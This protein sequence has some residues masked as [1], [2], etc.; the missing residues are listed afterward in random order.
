MGSD[1]PRGRTYDSRR[2][3]VALDDL[4]GDSVSGTTVV[5]LAGSVRVRFG[6]FDVVVGGTGQSNRFVRTRRSVV[7]EDP[8]GIAAQRVVDPSPVGA[9][10]RL[11]PRRRGNA[12]EV[13][14]RGDRRP[15]PS[16]LREAEPG[17]AQTGW[18]V[19]LGQQR[20]TGVRGRA[21][22]DDSPRFPKS[23]FR[24]PGSGESLHLEAH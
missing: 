19:H 16:Q 6:K 24:R 23:G 18:G 1:F 2:K 10:W 11:L 14:H 17:L 4:S 3:T 21:T 20:P 13:R 7:R 5:E 9:R 12:V 22:S 15:R 8:G